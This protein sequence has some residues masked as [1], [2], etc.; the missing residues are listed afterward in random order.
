MKLTSNT[1]LLSLLATAALLLS[2]CGGNPGG[3]NS[4]SIYGAISAGEAGYTVSTIAG[5]GIAGSLDGLGSLATFANPSAVAVDST[6]NVFVADTGNQ[7]IRKITTDGMVST[8]AGQVGQW[9]YRDGPAGSAMFYEPVGLVIDP[10]GNL[11]VADSGNSRIRK[12]TPLGEVSTYAGSGGDSIHPADFVDGPAL[13]AILGGPLGLTLDDLGNLYVAATNN[14]LI[15]KISPAG[16]ATTIAGVLSIDSS[17]YAPCSTGGSCATFRGPG[18]IARD[19]SGNLYVADTLNQTIRK[20]TPA[21]EV[22]TLAGSGVQGFADGAGASAQF[23][24]PFGLV[25]DSKGNLYISDQ[26]NSVIRKITQDGNVSTVAGQAGVSGNT[27]GPGAQATFHL[28]SGLAIDKDDTLYV[29]DYSNHSV[30]KLV[31]K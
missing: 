11:Y 3:G 21:G 10:I 2:A 31:L 17:A 5:T 16:Q 7:V 15:R 4:T 24:S 30:R 6:G 9:G 27:Q 25:V 22:S 8:F 13:L 1:Q 29:A 20:V 28:P 14:S 26:N 12:I 19:K 18:S 23:D